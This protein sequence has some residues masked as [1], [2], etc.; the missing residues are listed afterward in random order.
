MADLGERPKITSE[1][2]ELLHKIAGMCS[3]GG[4]GI[5]Q[6]DAKTDAKS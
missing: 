1:Q 5:V 2:W 3:T 6:G 4:D